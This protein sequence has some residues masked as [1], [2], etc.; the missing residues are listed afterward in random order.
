MKSIK[1]INIENREIKD[2]YSIL[3]KL[4]KFETEQ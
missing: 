4:M 1:M 2:I 3:N